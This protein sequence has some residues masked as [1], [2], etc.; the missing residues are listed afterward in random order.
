MAGICPAP[1]EPLDQ[2][3]KL[4]K[5]VREFTRPNHAGLMEYKQSLYDLLVNYL[6]AEQDL[7][8]GQEF[9]RE[10]A[11]VMPEYQRCRE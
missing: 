11:R 7:K 8:A 2:R 9:W 3:R 5:V 10:M 6:H 1:A 4:H